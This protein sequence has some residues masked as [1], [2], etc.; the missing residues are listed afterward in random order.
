ME[1]VSVKDAP[2][3]ILILQT[4]STLEVLS[5]LLASRA[6]AH[7]YPQAQL[8]FLTRE[9]TAAL[10]QRSEWIDEVLSLPKETK[11]LSDISKFVSSV[12]ERRYEVSVNWSQARSS[13]ILLD[14]IPAVVRLGRRIGANGEFED[15][16]AWSMVM[17][18]LEWGGLHQDIHIS[19]MQTTQVLTA[20]QIHVGEPQGKN[21]V[22]RQMFRALTP[23]LIPVWAQRPHGVRWVAIDGDD[24]ERLALESAQQIVRRHGDAG[25][26]WVGKKG[27]S[28]AMDR[29][30]SLTGKLEI[31]QYIQVLSH[32]QWLITKDP[33]LA[34]LASLLQVKV[35]MIAGVGASLSEAPYGNGHLRIVSPHNLSADFIHAVYSYGAT[36]WMHNGK[37]DFLKHLEQ[38]SVVADAKGVEVQ[39]SRIRQPDEG[40][41]VAYVDLLK[42]PTS[43]EEW[44]RIVNARVLR[45][46]LCGWVPDIDF[47]LAQIQAGPDLT[48]SIHKSSESWPVARRI[49]NEAIQSAI[50]LQGIAVERRSLRMMG[51]EEDQR[52]REIGAKIAELE[53]L[54]TR[55]AQVES[56]LAPIV[57]MQ[58]LLMHNLPGAGLSEVA[59]S[60]QQVWEM[61]GQALDLEEELAQRVATRQRNGLG[62]RADRSHLRLVD[63]E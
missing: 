12:L 17:H 44:D 45:S 8:T 31:D 1:A 47:D 15:C 26:V 58:R 21:V 28:V 57:Q 61:V 20:L 29:M 16:D 2:L 43:K 50:A 60:T 10:A 23:A 51:V 30:I 13:A 39:R 36:E 7:H 42:H 55:L 41:G 27:P 5:S 18:A 22:A 59:I 14:L 25:V 38:L 32:C 53:V 52:I 40:G 11:S 34:S 49:T 56:S 48:A 19:D 62:R 4:G 33:V 37:K 63:R 6:I 35:I 54:L 9:G 3:R 46:W 24:W